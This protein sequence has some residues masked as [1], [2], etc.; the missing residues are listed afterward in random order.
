MYQRARIYPLDPPVVPREYT[1]AECMQTQFPSINVV[2]RILPYGS[3]FPLGSARRGSEGLVLAAE[4]DCLECPGS[5]GCTGR[6]HF[7]HAG[8]LCR[9]RAARNLS[10]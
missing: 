7:T 9:Q 10:R 8:I 3:C 5:A 2:Q 6:Y 4:I 1:L